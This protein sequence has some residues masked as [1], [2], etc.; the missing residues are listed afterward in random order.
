MAWANYF[1]G[2]T[3]VFPTICLLVKETVTSFPR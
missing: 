3:L 1:P 2:R